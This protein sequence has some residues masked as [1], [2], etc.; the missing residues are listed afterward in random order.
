MWFVIKTKSVQKGTEKAAGYRFNMIEANIHCRMDN[1]SY[2]SLQS[3][4]QVLYRNKKGSYF[5]NK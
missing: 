3:K 2:S 5:M 4:N 1:H